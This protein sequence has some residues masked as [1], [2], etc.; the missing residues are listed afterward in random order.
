MITTTIIITLLVLST[1]IAAITEHTL[2]KPEGD[3]FVN[4]V[5]GFLLG[6]LHSS[7][8]QEIFNEEEEIIGYRDFHTVQIALFFI[9]FTFVWAGEIEDA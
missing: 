4:A 6:A 1:V 8:L 5:G 7:E 9:T 2:Y 3:V